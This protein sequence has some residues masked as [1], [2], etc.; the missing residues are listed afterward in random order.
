MVVARVRAVQHGI[1]IDHTYPKL[2]LVQGPIPVLAQDLVIDP[3]VVSRPRVD[4]VTS[5]RCL[6]PVVN[7]I[8]RRRCRQDLV[9][10]HELRVRQ[11]LHVNLDPVLEP[12]HRHLNYHHLGLTTVA[13]I[14]HHP[15]GDIVNIN[16]Y[17]V[18]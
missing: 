18:K 15:L 3:H 7:P 12:H 13:H 11:V 2:D 9:V 17:L 10:D 1:H 8:H 14:N 16:I 5:L 6:G 4:L